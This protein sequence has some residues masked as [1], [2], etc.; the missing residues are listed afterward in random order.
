MSIDSTDFAR[1]TLLVQR[2]LDAETL[3]ETEGEALLKT[4][5]TAHQ[6]LAQG[7]AAGE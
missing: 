5:Q 1:L 6:A 4:S 3:S 7:D 2:L